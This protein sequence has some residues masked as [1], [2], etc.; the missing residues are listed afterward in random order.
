MRSVKQIMP[1]MLMEICRSERP[2]RRPMRDGTLVHAVAT[3]S[4][5]PV[6]DVAFD[7]G[8]KWRH[9]YIYYG[10][11]LFPSRCERGGLTG[12]RR[13]PSAPA[14]RARS[15]VRVPRVFRP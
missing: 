11:T 7:N 10:E 1:H 4:T 9:N 2:P 13:T 12:R 8:A 5:R 6:A 15:V 3:V 14:S